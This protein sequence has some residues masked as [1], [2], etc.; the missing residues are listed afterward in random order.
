[1]E[2]VNTSTDRE[3]VNLAGLKSPSFISS[4]GSNPTLCKLGVNMYIIGKEIK[5]FAQ[6]LT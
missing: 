5:G 3:A 6:K 2:P 1:M 4:L